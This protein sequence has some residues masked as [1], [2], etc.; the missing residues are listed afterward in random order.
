MGLAARSSSCTWVL[1]YSV[2]N[3]QQI[4]SPPAIPPVHQKNTQK[5]IYFSEKIYLNFI[6]ILFDFEYWNLFHCSNKTIISAF[7]S[8]LFWKNILSCQIIQM[9]VTQFF[10][11]TISPFDTPPSHPQDYDVVLVSYKNFTGISWH[12]VKSKRIPWRFVTRIIFL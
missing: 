8:I 3:V 7:P 1:T 5:N 6:S 10:N 12:S 11:C 2:G 9:P 4:S